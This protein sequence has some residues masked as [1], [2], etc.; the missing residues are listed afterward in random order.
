MIP[1]TDE[2]RDRM[3]QAIVEAVDPEQVILFGSRTRG[4]A[5]EASDVDLVVVESEPFGKARSWRLEAVRLWRALS[6]FFIRRTSSSTTATRSSTGATLPITSWR[7]RFEKVRCFMSGLDDAR[8]LMEAA[9]RGLR[10]LRGMEDAV[11]FA[12]EIPGF[13]VQQ[14]SET[15]WLILLDEPYPL[16][17]DPDH[18]LRLVE[19]REPDAG[20]FEDPI[21]YRPY[22]IQLRYGWYEEET[23][24]IDRQKAAECLEALRRQV[25][26]RLP[27][28]ERS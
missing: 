5:R 12:D 8:S 4:D 23:A 11:V 2:L 19:R 25:R 9:E 27:D 28:A 16:I 18:L 15:L 7:V 20:R 14:A 13:H 22:A 3:V 1:V 21:E 6:N 10:A 26:Q 17:H 24:P